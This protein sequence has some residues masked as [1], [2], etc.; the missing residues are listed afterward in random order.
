MNKL[1]KKKFAK[2]FLLSLLVSFLMTSCNE[3]QQTISDLGNS[4]MVEYGKTV[5][6]DLKVESDKAIVSFI[7][8]AQIFTLDLSKNERKE[9]LELLNKCIKNQIPLNIFL[10][11]HTTEIVKIEKVSQ[12]DIDYFKNLLAKKDNDNYHKAI[13]IVAV[14]PNQATLTTLFNKIKMRAC[15]QSTGTPPSEPCITFGYA[16]DGCFARAHKMRQILATNGYE[17]EKQ[18]VY[19]N[20]K[21]TTGSCCVNWSYHVA[22]LVKFKN[23]NGN[24]EERIIDPSLFPNGPVLPSTWR[25]ACVNSTCGNSPSISSFTNTTSNVYYRNAGG[26]TV[27]YDDSYSK[28]NCTLSAYRNLLGCQPSPAPLTTSCGR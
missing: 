5:P 24:I 1:T 4:K 15:F 25:N 16:V 12:E 2:A 11:E 27:L 18:F 13:A 8:T 7:L 10:K 19:G 17:C 3:E 26:S 21:A 9:D 22:P 6:V 20:L 14:I 23:S 28:T